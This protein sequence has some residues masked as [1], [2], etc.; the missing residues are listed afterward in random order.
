MSV[1]LNIFLFQELMRL[2]N[3]IAII[4]QT[5]VDLVEVK[6]GN[7]ILTSELQASGDALF[8][9][10]VPKVWLYDAGGV[11]I[12]WMTPTLGSWIDNLQRRVGQFDNWMKNGRPSHYWLAGFFN[13][14]GFLTAVKQEVTRQ[15]KAQNWA[16]DDVVEVTEVKDI[17][18]NRIREVPTEGVY[19][20]GLY[21]EGA[22]WNRAGGKLEELNGKDT[23]V[24][25]SIIYVTAKSRDRGAKGNKEM[26]S[27]GLYSCPCYKYPMRTD[28][29]YVFHV[30]LN[31]G[32]GQSNALHWKLRGVALLCSRE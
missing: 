11:E 19:V 27:Y 17:D 3:V 13:P 1:P 8:D 25:M 15:N 26:D 21:L 20:S 23:V 14:Q 30:N 16:L 9:G 2:Q 18:I 28:R 4:K 24:D 22:M 6:L 29:Y 12:S 31:S 32:E 7:I 5:L 10:R